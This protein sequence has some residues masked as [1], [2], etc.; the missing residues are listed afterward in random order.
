MVC[1]Q[2]GILII[3]IFDTILGHGSSFLDYRFQGNYE[4]Q[5]KFCTYIVFFAFLFA[6]FLYLHLLYSI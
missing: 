5:F 4:T 6:F 3:D 2:A 1:I